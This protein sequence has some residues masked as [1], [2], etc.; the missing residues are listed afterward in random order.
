MQTPNFHGVH[1]WNRLQWAK[2]NLEPFRTEYCVIYEDD[3]DEPAKVMHPDPNWM[4]AALN[5]GIVP[6]IE[7]ILL[8]RE[9]ASR[10]DFKKHTLGYVRDNAKP[11]D[12]MT[13]K[14]AVEYQ[15]MQSI[16]KEVW[17][18]WNEGNYPKMVICKKDQLPKTRLWRNT[19]KIN[20]ELEIE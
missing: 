16:P 5:G 14:E 12:A 7:T 3:M 13:E 15:I 18:S 1:Y 6:P 8:M 19:W 9:D 4:A 11:C 17:S 2:D 20:T 10:P